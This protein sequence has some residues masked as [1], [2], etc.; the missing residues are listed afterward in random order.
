[1]NMDEQDALCCT[2]P[3]GTISKFKVSSGM[4]LLVLLL[5]LVAL[6]KLMIYTHA[7]HIIKITIKMKALR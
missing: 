5:L 6:V 7:T 3:I 2:L 1:M 4:I